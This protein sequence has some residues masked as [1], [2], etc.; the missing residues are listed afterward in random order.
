MRELLMQS[1]L[2]LLLAGT[3]IIVLAPLFL[4]RWV[5]K[6]RNRV[7]FDSPSRRIVW[8]IAASLFA[9]LTIGAVLSGSGSNLQVFEASGLARKLGLPVAYLL[10]SIAA[11]FPYRKGSPFY[12]ASRAPFPLWWWALAILATISTALAVVIPRQAMDPLAVVESSMFVVGFLLSAALG[13]RASIWTDRD[14]FGILAVL[15]TFAVVAGFLQISLGS[16]VAMVFP[17][18]A[19][20]IYA[21]ILRRRRFLIV[22]LLGISLAFVS[23]LRLSQDNSPSLAAIMQG[24]ICGAILVLAI[25]PKRLRLPIVS[26]AGIASCFFVASSGI[27]NLLLG[28]G[29][30]AEDVTLAHRAYEAMQ[31]RLLTGTDVASTLF[32]LGPAASVD[33]SSSPDAATLLSSG[34]TLNAVDDVHFLTSWLVL[35]LGLLGLLWFG[36]LLYAL[37]R[38]AFHVLRKPKPDFFDTGILFFVAAGLIHSIPAATY[39]FSNPLPALLLGVLY[40]RRVSLRKNDNSVT[41]GLADEPSPIVIA[42]GSRNSPLSHPS[43]GYLGRK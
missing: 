15:A 2:V 19:M 27:V 20:L 13:F 16:Y 6:G 40:A 3:P 4:L 1:P 31:V 18:A 24:V 37:T 11:I 7:T 36:A 28:D 38:E 14:E 22:G 5:R 26:L 29:S 33:L 9:S 8:A 23:G 43:T 39:L 34:R 17:A 12:G 10:L 41:E 21:A 35:K 30:A 42:G 32:G 25:L